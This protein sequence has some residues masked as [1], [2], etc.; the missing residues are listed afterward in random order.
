MAIVA[1]ARSAAS[2]SPDSRRAASD[3][4]RSNAPSLA[5]SVRSVASPAAMAS[6]FPESVPAWYTSPAGAM[7][8]SSARGPPYAPTGSPPPTTLPSAVRS[9]RT[10]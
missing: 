8:S 2:R 3:S 5:R 1:P 10:P 7:R 9:G 6:G 4:R